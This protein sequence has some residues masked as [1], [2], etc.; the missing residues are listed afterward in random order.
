MND[1]NRHDR[2]FQHKGLA[3]LILWIGFNL[4]CSFGKAS[5]IALGDPFIQNYPTTVYQAGI[6]N[7]A[8]DQHPNGY[9]FLAN[10]NGLL[11]FDGNDWRCF[12]LAKKTIA[13]SLLIQGDSIFVGGQNEFGYFKA[14]ES[15]E[16]R[17]HS[18]LQLV[19]ERFRNFEDVWEIVPHKGSIY[20]YA[21]NRLYQLK[22]QCISV[23]WEA[24]GIR[25][26]A[27]AHGRLFIQS[28]DGLF[29]KKGKEY[30]SLELPTAVRE[31]LLLTSA[32]SID[33]DK[34]QFTTLKEGF[35]LL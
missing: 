11:Q 17:Y 35:F 5:D 19:P 25:F 13:R 23:S 1:L 7:W 14:D 30:I 29:E 22:N 12:P 20:F 16:L 8:I 27:E 32:L 21:S 33:Q 15:G 24:T 26:L 3:Y 4:F 9:I 18:L 6:Q 2:I 28:S 34:V 10:N 31:N